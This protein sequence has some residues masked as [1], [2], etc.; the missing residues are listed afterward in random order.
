[1]KPGADRDALVAF[2]DGLRETKDT[3]V[4]AAVRL[5][6]EQAVSAWK[7]GFNRALLLTMERTLGLT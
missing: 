7:D 4:P 3:H 2:L 6:G 1:M 5:A